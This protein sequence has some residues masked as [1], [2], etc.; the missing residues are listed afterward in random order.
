MAEQKLTMFQRN[1]VNYHLRN[2]DPLPLPRPIARR[3]RQFDYEEHL[4]SEIM[5]RARSARKRTLGE[6]Q[7][8]GA[9]EAEK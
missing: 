1:R 2:G 7:A 6:I 3:H 8:S 9:L 4:A 5:Q